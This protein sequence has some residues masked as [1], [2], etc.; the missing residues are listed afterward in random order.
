MIRP[1]LVGFI[2]V[3]IL[4]ACGATGDSADLA[5]AGVEE[6]AIVAIQRRYQFDG[7]ANTILSRPLTSSEAR[8]VLCIRDCASRS[9]Y[10]VVLEGKFDSDDPPGLP[11]GVSYGPYRFLGAV[12]EL[13]SGHIIETHASSSLDDVRANIDVD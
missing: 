13:S 5:D 6:R 3:I 10:V 8:K 4:A 1:L 12:I 11:A 9:Y 7:P 2:L